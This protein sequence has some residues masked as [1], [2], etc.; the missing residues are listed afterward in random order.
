MGSSWGFVQHGDVIKSSILIST[1]DENRYYSK[2][3]WVKDLV[4]TCSC[5]LH[6]LGKYQSATVAMG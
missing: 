2:I 4:S 3:N 5:H 6:Q 1:S